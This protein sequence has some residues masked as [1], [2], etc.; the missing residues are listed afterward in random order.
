LNMN[1]TGNKNQPGYTL[2]E[3]LV[4]LTILGALAAVVIPRVIV[5]AGRGKVDAANTEAREVEMAVAAAMEATK[6]AANTFTSI[7]P[8][9]TGEA[10]GENNDPY[11]F[12]ANPGSLQAVYSLDAT[13]DIT[14]AIVI[15]NS[16]WGALT[17]DAASGY[18][19]K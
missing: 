18:W 17:Y 1:N 15:S 7:S 4:V 11:D 3:L 10:A 5:F 9:L 13:G 8:A 16:R 12:I 19:G 14:A 6:A 2:I